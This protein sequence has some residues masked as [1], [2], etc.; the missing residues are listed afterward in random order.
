MADPAPTAVDAPAPDYLPNPPEAV[1]GA[2]GAVEAELEEG[3]TAQMCKRVGPAKEALLGWLAK[4]PSG[5]NAAVLSE[6]VAASLDDFMAA[7]PKIEPEQA[8]KFLRRVKRDIEVKVKP[9]PP[10]KPR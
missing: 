3:N 5:R 9:P 7:C 2:L 10:L 1:W 6:E 4:L 8:R